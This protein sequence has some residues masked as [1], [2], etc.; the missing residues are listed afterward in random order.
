MLEEWLQ[1]EDRLIAEMADAA[2]GPKRNGLFALWLF[3]RLCGGRLPAQPVSDRTHRKR[4]DNVQRRLSSLSLPAPIR[5]AMTASLEDLR[6]SD[7]VSVSLRQLV[8][9][10]RE[11]LGPGAAEAMALAAKIAGS[12]A[13]TK[14]A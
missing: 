11:T 6:H 2:R 3:V 5:R 9:P 4:L 10:A 12:S 8:A 13:P 1:V 7:S 14:V